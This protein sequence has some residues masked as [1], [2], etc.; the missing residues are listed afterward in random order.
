LE[1]VEDA[2]AGGGRGVGG[3]A[4]PPL[5][6]AFVEPTI[7][8]G[9]RPGMRAYQEELFGP[10]ALVFRVDDDDEAVTLANDSPYGLSGSVFSA[11]LERARRVA[12]RID[13]GMV[14]INHPAMSRPELPFGGIKRSGYGRELAALGMLEFANRKLICEVSP[15]APM[16]SF[17]G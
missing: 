8:T 15:N 3:G 7:L 12:D 10:V 6:G 14:F 11:D 17:A 1:G 5:P 13:S 2:L 4:P 9:V 16:R